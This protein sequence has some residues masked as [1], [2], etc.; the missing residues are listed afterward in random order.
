MKPC[1]D[2]GMNDRY[3]TSSGKT[4]SYCYDCNYIRLREYQKTS[5]GKESLKTSNKKYLLSDNGREAIRKA[6]RNHNR[7]KEWF[8]SRTIL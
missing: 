3:T 4:Y 2:C 6:S 5:K 7:K 1:K 8:Y